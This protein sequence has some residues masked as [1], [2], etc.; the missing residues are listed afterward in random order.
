MKRFK[1]PPAF[2][3]FFGPLDKDQFKKIF[4]ILEKYSP[5]SRKEKKERL[6]TEDFVIAN[7]EQI[8]DDIV[9]AK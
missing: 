6:Q 4:K 7:S 8:S 2:A 3:Q 1:C 9:E 5:E